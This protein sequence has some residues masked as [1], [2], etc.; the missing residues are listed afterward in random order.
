[1]TYREGDSAISVIMVTYYTGP[2]LARS[3]AAARAQ[4]GVRDVVIVDN[5]NW[6]GAVAAAIGDDDAGAPVTVIAGHGN[7]G[8]AAACNLG[9]RAAAGELFL[10]INPDAILPPGAAVRLA[11]DGA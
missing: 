5:G 9:A 8:F 11:A 3:I 4:A 10:F 2:V 1:M 6:D 7:I